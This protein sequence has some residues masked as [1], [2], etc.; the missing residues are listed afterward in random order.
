MVCCSRNFQ[1]EL[2]RSWTGYDS[3]DG[4]RIKG[5]SHKISSDPLPFLVAGLCRIYTG[6]P[7]SLFPGSNRFLTT[8]RRQRRDQASGAVDNQLALTG[9]LRNLLFV[10]NPPQCDHHIVYSLWISTALAA[11]HKYFISCNT[12]FPC[13]GKK[14]WTTGLF[15]LYMPFMSRLLKALYKNTRKLYN[16][17]FVLKETQ[18]ITEE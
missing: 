9:D 5:N 18:G 8:P 13:K 2:G 17:S 11:L 16:R 7:L 6:P 10:A 12:S 14:T 3:T 1:Q 4:I 15:I